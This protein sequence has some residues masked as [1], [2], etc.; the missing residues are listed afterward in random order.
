MRELAFWSEVG[1]AELEEAATRREAILNDADR[2]TFHELDRR[3]KTFVS[4]LAEQY[5]TVGLGSPGEEGKAYSD[6]LYS[7][8]GVLI[9]LGDD[10]P[11]NVTAKIYEIA[12][13]FGLT[14]Y[15]PQAEF[16]L[17]VDDDLGVETN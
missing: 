8:L 10:L 7:R 14:M 2:V 5:P 17:G 15:H 3:M 9:Q 12:A 4:Q 6:L 16:V 13:S 11:D 1:L